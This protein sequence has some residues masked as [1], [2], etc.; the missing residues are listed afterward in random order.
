MSVFDFILALFVFVY[1]AWSIGFGACVILAHQTDKEKY[2]LNWALLPEFVKNLW[3]DFPQP[4]QR[5]ATI[6]FFG[7]PY[8]T[9]VVLEVVGTT[10][11]LV[12]NF[13]Q[14]K[15]QEFKNQNGS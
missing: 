6:F 15:V 8:A 3:K 9:Y 5:A 14:N 4:Q 2:P 1:F 12:T 13:V 10:F 11:A 7:P